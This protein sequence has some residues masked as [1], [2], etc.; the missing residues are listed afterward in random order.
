M[1]TSLRI[2]DRGP[3]VRKLQVQVNRTLRER[4]FS[5][6]TIDVDEIFGEET[7][8][9]ARFTGWLMGFT[10]GELE[11]IEEGRITARSFGFL[12]RETAKTDAMR[13]R[14]QDREPMAKKLRSLHKHPAKAPAAR[15]V[16]TFEGVPVAGWMVKFL[17]KSRAKGWQGVVV[18]GFRSPEHSEKVCFDM[19]G[20][21]TCP[22]RCAGRT[23][24]HAGLI[25]PAGAIDITETERF[26][27]IQAKI[28]SPL[29]NDLPNDPVHFSVSGH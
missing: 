28:G 15:G 27:A 16:G 1:A 5:F 20:Q 14:T 8:K 3:A 11:K 12:V 7:Q 10:R 25:H 21:P 24:N 29:R 9:A 22:G 19:C 26:A 4:E 23:S 17:N 13:R 18:S 2:G 6:R